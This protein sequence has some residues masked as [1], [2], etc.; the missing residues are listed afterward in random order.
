[1]G[2]QCGFGFLRLTQG[3]F[4][5]LSCLLG[6]SLRLQSNGSQFPASRLCAISGLILADSQVGR[7]AHVKQNKRMRAAIKTLR[8]RVCR[9]QCD[10]QRQLVNKSA[11]L[12]QQV[13]AKG[14]DLPQR[15]GRILTQKT[16]NKNK[17]YALHAPEVEC[18]SKGKARNPTTDTRWMKTLSR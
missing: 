6:L 15:V 13:Q 5:I 8:T 4:C 2:A 17:R 16:K 14:L 18:I 1:M 3:R 12:P 9:V 11:Q 10:V 7:Y